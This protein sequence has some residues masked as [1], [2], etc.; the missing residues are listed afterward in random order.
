MNI[1]QVKELAGRLN[2]PSTSLSE[3]NSYIAELEAIGSSAET[4]YSGE[5]DLRYK[6]SEELPDPGFVGSPSGYH[7][8]KDIIK[9]YHFQ[10]EYFSVTQMFAAMGYKALRLAESVD[11]SSLSSLM[12]MVIEKRKNLE[13][14]VMQLLGNINAVLKSIIAIITELRELD[15]NIYFYDE[16][17]GSDKDKSEAAELALKRI[18]LDNVDARKGGASLSALSRSPTQGQGGPG[19]IDVMS[20]FYQVKSLK[21]V[22]Q[23]ERNEQYKNILKN[24]YIEYE[25]WKEI[26]GKDLRTRKSLLLQYLKSQMSSFNMYVDWC[27]TYLSMLSK[28]GLKTAMNAN[29]YIRGSSKPDIFESEVFS[30]SAAGYKPIYSREYDVEYAKLFKSKGPEIPIKVTPKSLETSL[31]TRGYKEQKRSFIYERL[32][33]YGPMTYSFIKVIMDFKE[34]PSKEAIQPPYEGTLYFNIYPYVF[35]PDEFYLYRT[36]SLAKIQK[37]VFTAV[38]QSVFGSLS[39]IKEDLDKYVKEAE[40]EEEEKKKPKKAQKEYAILDIYRSFKDDI[41]GISKSFSGFSNS[42]IKRKHVFNADDTEKYEMILNAKLFPK[43][44]IKTALETGLFI[45]NNDTEHIYD[46]SKKRVGL[47][48][49]RPPFVIN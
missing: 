30:V 23:L 41:F 21:D 38:D 15:R 44:S 25:K 7:F 18:F 29:D 33:K 9:R 16:I 11:P 39:I 43:S 1:T 45:A 22:V 24:R 27:S 13:D 37:T 17:K 35:T 8:T 6:N 46:E 28:M 14:R 47:L 20:V 48:N 26:N 2:S 3:V 10:P 34:K 19:F 36:A 32:K 4:H 31:L 5:I 40:K 49:W 12:N 42:D